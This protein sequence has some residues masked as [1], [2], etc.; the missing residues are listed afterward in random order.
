M[1]PPVEKSEVFTTQLAT[2]ALMF[3]MFGLAMAIPVA[4]SM[5]FA[6]R[7]R[8]FFP[9]TRSSRPVWTA[10]GPV[11]AAAPTDLI[12]TTV[13]LGL[14]AVSRPRAVENSG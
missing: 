7:Q 12:V 5:W 6:Y 11:G 9:R 4:L 10:T 1:V 2:K 3:V 13:V 14:L 8:P